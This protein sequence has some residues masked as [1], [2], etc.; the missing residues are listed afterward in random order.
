[1]PDVPRVSP[2][3]NVEA[4]RRVELLPLRKTLNSWLTYSLDLLF[5]PR[6]AGC[7]RVDAQWCARCQADIEALPFQFS[8]KVLTHLTACAATGVHD[9]KLRDALHALKYE[10]G[11]ALAYALAGRLHAALEQADWQVDMIAPVPLHAA[12]LAERGYNQAGLLAEALALRSGIPTMPN[13]LERMKFTQSQVGLTAQE[14]EVNVQDA[15]R[16]DAVQVNGRRVLLI[17]DVYTTGATLDA[18]ASAALAAGATCVYGL[19]VSAALH[20]AP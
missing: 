12:R 2:T 16:A 20:R 18:C 3:L 11:Q 13:A 4:Q 10:D 14:R 6:C 5:P 1:M 15:F 9:G 7:G 8:L 19:T 17:D